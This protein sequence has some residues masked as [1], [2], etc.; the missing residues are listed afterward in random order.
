M[1]CAH[2]Q[3]KRVKKEYRKW[4]D[5][6]RLDD[7]GMLGIGAHRVDFDFLA[8][9][10][11]IDDGSQLLNELR[12]GSSA[13]QSSGVNETLTAPYVYGEHTVHHCNARVHPP[14]PFVGNVE[15]YQHGDEAE[16]I[17]AHVC[18]MLFALNLCCATFGPSAPKVEQPLRD[19]DG[20]EAYN[21]EQ[22]QTNG[23]GFVRTEDLDRLKDD[24]ERHHAH[25]NREDD[26][27]DGL[28]A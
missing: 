19:D 27:A 9:L 17:T 15:G 13:D 23:F 2:L 21:V 10:V 14:R 28:S 22:T 1:I 26:D 12:V 25:N 8:R 20:D 4:Y 5:G 3:K 16:G 6:A 18:A 7:T 24:V 11:M